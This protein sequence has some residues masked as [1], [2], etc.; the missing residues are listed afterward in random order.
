MNNF[1]CQAIY[2]AT[3][4]PRVLSSHQNRA[5]SLAILRTGE[6]ASGLEAS[7]YTRF[8]SEYKRSFRH[9]IRVG[10]ATEWKA[11]RDLEGHSG[12][13]ALPSCHLEISRAVHATTR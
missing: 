7:E 13:Y 2:F 10:N 12:D 6:I 4:A 9:K 3:Q 11:P 5:Y 8:P 1:D